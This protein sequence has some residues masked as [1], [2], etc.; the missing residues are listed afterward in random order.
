MI[1]ISA[2]VAGILLAPSLLQAQQALEVGPDAVVRVPRRRSLEPTTAMTLECWVKPAGSISHGRILRKS[3]NGYSGYLLSFSSQGPYVSAEFLSQGNAYM[4]RDLQ[5][6]S[7]YIGTWHHLAMTVRA[8]GLMHLY[9]DGDLAATTNAPP[10]LL[11][12]ADLIIGGALLGSLPDEEFIGLIDEVRL[13]DIERTEQQIR[14]DRARWIEA[15]PG[16]ISMWHFDGTLDDAVGSN[17]GIFRGAEFVPS[18]APISRRF[19][20]SQRSGS[21]QGGEWIA[22]R[23]EFPLGQTPSEVRFG[24]T[25]AAALR[26]VD[27]ETIEVRVPPGEAG[28]SVHLT[29]HYGAISYGGTQLYAYLP[30]LVVP[31]TALLGA[32]LAVR[33]ETLPPGTALLFAGLPPPVAIA[34]PPFDGSLAIVPPVIELFAGGIPFHAIEMHLQVPND[35]VWI[36]QEILFQAFFA[37]TPIALGGTFTLPRLV[38]VH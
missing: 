8:G 11:H 32:T 13:W 22:L 16:L 29:V 3:D 14:A 19:T 23:G 25:Q 18:D 26:V 15:E 10:A 35:P 34:V 12:S 21:W 4:A 38:R 27:P 31:A 30:S 5:P 36:G 6:N 9:I 7:T 1:R 28:S 2:L 33:L 24:T 37:R 17:H 20:S